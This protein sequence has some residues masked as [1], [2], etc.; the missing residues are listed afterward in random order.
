MEE[1]VCRCGEEM[2]AKND[3]IGIKVDGIKYILEDVDALHCDDCRVYVLTK[4]EVGLIEKAIR[5]AVSV[6]E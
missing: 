2:V 1:V 5:A 6:H 4:Y 3:D